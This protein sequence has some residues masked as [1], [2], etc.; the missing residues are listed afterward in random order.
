MLVII[1][2]IPTPYRTAFF[3]VL[4][5]ELKKENI[6][7][8]VIYC[9][10]TEPRRSWLFSPEENNYNYSF[11]RSIDINLRNYYLH[12][13]YE[14]ISILKE[15]KP[16]WLILGGSWNAFSTIQVLLCKKYISTQILLWS[17]G[18]LESKRNS[19]KIIESLR[20]IVFNSVN[21]F[22]VPN[23]KS[24]DYIRVYNKNSP[25]GF[26][27]NTVDE[28]FFSDS[29]MLSKESIIR[30]YGVKPSNRILIC[31]ARLDNNKGVFDLMKAYSSLDYN[32]KDNLSIVYVGSGELHET[33]LNYK[34]DNKLENVF[35]LGQKDQD[36][37]KELLYVSDA[38][39]LPTKLDSNPLTPIEASFMKKPLI[40]SKLAGNHDE[41]VTVNTGISI[42]HINETELMKV[43][44]DFQKM[45]ESSLSE[46]SIGAF[47]NVYNSF[48]RKAV[49]L[50][51]IEFLLD[52][53]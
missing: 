44:I 13:N 21:G 5:H 39:I 49:S 33:M 43:L 41:L 6:N 1:T 14:L 2:N 31:V 12:L 35:L 50:N 28:D 9:A 40:L 10:K 51:L 53:K 25:I 48:S 47:E 52:K 37:V 32:I 11:L 24:M 3:N 17:E 46:M 27:P 7:L 22:V 45:D 30:K 16:T 19:S 36:E 20:S 18:H 4:S 34:V 8:H 38:F 26:L 15:L 29:S 23:I 42:N